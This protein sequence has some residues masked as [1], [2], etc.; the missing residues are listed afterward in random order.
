M[1]KILLATTALVGI[2]LTG[3]AQ[4]ATSP[5]TV[6]LGGDVDFIAA[7]FATSGKGTQDSTSA[8]RSMESLFDLDVSVKG[9][10]NNGVEYGGLVALSNAPSISNAFHGTSTPYL[11]EGYT[12]MSG[13]F[14]K[15]QLGDE[16]GATDLAVSA[17]VVGEGQVMG[18]FIDFTETNS[19][20]KNF[21]AGV[22][23]TD[24]ATN[25]TYYTP[26]VGNAN[27]KVQLGVSYVPQMYNYGSQTTL[28][29][30]GTVGQ[31]NTLSPYHDVF[32]GAL[33]YD[34]NIAPVAVK[35]A[36]YVIT[37]DASGGGATSYTWTNSAPAGNIQNFT[38]WGL[39]AQGALDGFTLGA[40]Y[41]S[42]GHYDA[43]T[44]QDKSQ[45]TY[46]AGLKYEFNKAAVGVSYLGG[47][48]YANHMT[49]AVTT[50][51]ATSDYVSTY[52][53]YGAGGSYTWAPGLTSNLD[54]VY[55]DQKTDASVENKGY[56]LLVSQ[57]LAF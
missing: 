45:H 39:G 32:K 43:V 24:H 17:P 8:N 10:A 27:N 51:A 11:S 50:A 20:A 36:G 28:N 1:R 35:A 53:S 26:K 40:G 49:S 57:K 46:N 56:V 54:G 4:A 15:V 38:A 34:G 7:N 9:K 2:A 16:R 18:R 41:D 12:W 19:F 42:Q 25:V 33:A 30:T 55:F 22:D 21:V 13:A 6:N 31:T 52:N 5:L 14:G 47:E 3:A 29:Q 37:G 44:G 48:G 23:G